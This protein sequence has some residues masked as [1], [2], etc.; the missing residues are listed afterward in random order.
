M[1]I[2]QKVV[3]WLARLLGVSNAT[4]PPTGSATA[5]EAGLVIFPYNAPTSEKAYLAAWARAMQTEWGRAIAT[6]YSQNYARELMKRCPVNLPTS[7]RAVWMAGQDAKKEVYGALVTAAT[8]NV[9]LL[10]EPKVKGKGSS[11]TS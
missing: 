5:P 10:T 7:E 2:R 8:H 11:P 4:P 9:T 6:F 3:D 1:G